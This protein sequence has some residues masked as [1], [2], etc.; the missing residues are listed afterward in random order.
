MSFERKKEKISMIDQ[1]QFIDDASYNNNGERQ[2]STI[3]YL[4]IE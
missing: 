2:K 1:E 4:E 3:P